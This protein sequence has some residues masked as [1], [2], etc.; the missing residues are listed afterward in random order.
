MCVSATDEIYISRWGVEK[1]NAKY[2]DRTSQGAYGDGTKP[3]VV[4]F[5]AQCI[6][7]IAT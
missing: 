4:F 2:V 5:P 7:D 3:L 1:Y 6:C